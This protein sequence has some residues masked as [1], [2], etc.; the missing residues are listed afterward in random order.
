MFSKIRDLIMFYSMKQ[1]SLRLYLCYR[2]CLALGKKEMVE[3]R[4]CTKQM[5]KAIDCAIEVEKIIRTTPL[6]P[7]SA[8]LILKCMELRNSFLSQIKDFSKYRAAAYQ[9][10]RCFYRIWQRP[11]YSWIIERN[12]KHS[13][14]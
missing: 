6:T 4:N 11:S 2:K 14:A 7:D 8:S 1:S 10:A 12:P 13:I 5:R 3:Y 9:G